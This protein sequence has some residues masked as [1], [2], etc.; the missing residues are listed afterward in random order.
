[1][2]TKLY[3][4]YQYGNILKVL[5]GEHEGKLARKWRVLVIPMFSNAEDD[6]LDTSFDLTDKKGILVAKMKIVLSHISRSGDNI[7]ESMKKVDHD[8]SLMSSLPSSL[9]TLRQV[10]GLTKTIMDQLVSQVCT[11]FT[12]KLS[13]RKDLKKWSTIFSGLYGVNHFMKCQNNSILGINLLA[14]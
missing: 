4:G 12:F 8:V 6:L 5:V 10:L 11:S 14:E 9:S 13:P 1:V 3:R 2:K 7:E